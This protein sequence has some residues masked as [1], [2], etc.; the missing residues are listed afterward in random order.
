MTS[1]IAKLKAQARAAAG[2]N[3]PA[4]HA[5]KPFL[6]KIRDAADAMAKQGDDP[7]QHVLETL[8]G[9]VVGGVERISTKAIFEKL[10]VPPRAQSTDV[11]QRL[12]R[13]MVELGW[14]PI[15]AHGLN[16]R[17]FLTRVRG[18]CRVASH[19]GTPRLPPNTTK[20]GRR[21][22]PLM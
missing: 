9:H 13:R 21:P 1:W 19:D 11:R 17:G 12:R 15:R 3:A 14:E 6:K 20:A 22:Q 10:G 8:R 2:D 7:W 4:E 16:S 18:Y 5:D